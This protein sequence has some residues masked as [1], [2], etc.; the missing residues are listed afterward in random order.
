MNRLNRIALGVVIL[1][2]V[3][4]NGG[5]GTAGTHTIAARR[6]TLNEAILTALQQNPDILRA[7]QDIERTKGLF[8]EMRAAAMP[9]VIATA[10]FQDLDP[11]INNISGVREQPG[12]SSLNQVGAERTYSLQLAANQVIFSGGRVPGQ[13]SSAT[14]Q[15]DSSYY[16][17]RNAIDQVVATVRQQFYLV[18]LDRALIG[19]QEESVRLLQSQLQDQ[20]NRFEAGTVPR[21]N[22]LQAQVAL[23]NQLPQLITARNNYTIS[24]LQLAK[25]LGLDF[26]PRR[27]DRPPLEAVGELLYV[28]REMPVTQA[29]ALAKENRPFLKQQ[30]AIVLS[31]N[32]NVR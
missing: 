2:A 12:T 11:H 30:K 7:R 32:S 5:E 23:S 17:F 4:A 16:A 18:L 22:V 10:Q 13:I 27:G 25:T 6:F 28:P 8:I 20:Q 14:F 15:R 1:L 21:F 26:D 29:I 19:V 3:Q 31:N 24:Q 9:Q